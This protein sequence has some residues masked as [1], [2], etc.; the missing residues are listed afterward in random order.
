[1]TIIYH[2][3]TISRRSF[4]EE[5]GAFATGLILLPGLSLAKQNKRLTAPVLTVLERTT[6]PLLKA[7]RPWEDYSI[8][9]NSVLKIGDNWHLWYVAYDHNYKNR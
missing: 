6:E 3:K 5:T 2:P 7:D 8:G 1:M 4:I 9:F